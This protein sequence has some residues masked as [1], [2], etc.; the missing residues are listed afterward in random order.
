MIGSRYVLQEFPG[1]LNL[2][3]EIDP[4]RR[5]FDIGFQRDAVIQWQQRYILTF[6]RQPVRCLC[7]QCWR[8][9]VGVQ[10]FTPAFERG[11]F[12]GQLHR[13]ALLKLATG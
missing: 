8:I 10:G 4:V 12:C 5:G 2:K 9:C 1:F 13:A 6:G 3:R 7:L 11:S